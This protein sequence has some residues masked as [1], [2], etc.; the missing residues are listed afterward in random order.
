MIRSDFYTDFDFN[1]S[2]HPRTGDITTKTNEEAVKQ[3]IRNLVLTRNFERPFRS[4]LGSQAY[5]LLFDLIT[6]MTETMVEKSIEDCIRNFEPRAIVIS[7]SVLVSPENNSV[8]ITIVFKI[9]NTES[10]I[11][12]GLTLERTR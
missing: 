1:F 10:P 12:V 4:Y 11:T 2:S 9:K 8:Y 5:D 3:S 7:V 6:P